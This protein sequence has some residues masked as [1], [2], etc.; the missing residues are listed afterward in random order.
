MSIPATSP[1]WMD[2]ISSW[3]DAR[4]PIEGDLRLSQ[5]RIYILPSRPGLL[6]ATVLGCMLLAAM[7]YQLALGYGLTFLLGAVGLV[8]ILHTFRNLNGLTL[9]PGRAEP[10]FAGQLAEFSLVLINSDKRERFAIGFFGKGMARNLMVDASPQAETVFSIAVPTTQRGWLAAPRLKLFTTFPLG[11]WRAWSYWLPGMKVL[12]YPT[13]EDNGPGLPSSFSGNASAN[14][15]ARGDEEIGGLREYQAG[16]HMA[17]IAWKA[18]A[19]HPEGKLL[20]KLME[21]SGQGDLS[22]DW[23]LLPVQLG[24]E[25][26]ISRLTRWVLQAEQEGQRFSLRLP[27][28]Q[29]AC[30]AGPA[31]VTNCLQA[32]ALLPR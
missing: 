15:S 22:L 19:R 1:G 25:V 24:R 18:V 29:I 8:A 32:L 20:T 30:D 27:D 3:L 2:R 10:V 9:K 26:K 13:P 4:R 28:Q 7:N 21:G 6:Y 12:V 17:H 11:L 5:N 16:D 14:H 31:H 23:F